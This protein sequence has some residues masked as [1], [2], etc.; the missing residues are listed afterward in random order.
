[1]KKVEVEGGIP[2]DHLKF[3]T[4]FYRSYCSRT[5]W[6]DVNGKY[7]DMDEKVR[8]LPDPDYPVYGCDA[9]WNTFWNPVTPSVSEKW[10]RSLLEID[11]R[12]G[13]LPKGP[14]GIEY[15]SIMTAEHEIALI[16]AAWQAGTRGFDGE[17]ALAAMVHCQTVPG[18]PYPG[19]G[20]VGNRDLAKI[21]R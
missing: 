2:E 10:V 13:W 4:N 9:F 12:G 20:H 11:A 17:K 5:I 16:V 19:G 7:V 14:T 15:S 21:F 8:E 6:S 18:G 1:M 3:Y